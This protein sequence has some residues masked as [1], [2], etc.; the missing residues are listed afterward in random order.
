MSMSKR[1]LRAVVAGGVFFAAFWI[2]E[3][4]LSGDGMDR[5]VKT[6]IMAVMFAV[7]SFFSSW[8]GERLRKKRPR[9]LRDINAEIRR[10]LRSE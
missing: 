2:V 1:V 6:A 3:D 8:I 10:T 9:S 4:L 7:L 5:V